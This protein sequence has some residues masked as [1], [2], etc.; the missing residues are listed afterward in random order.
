M[1]RSLLAGPGS[2]ALEEADIPRPRRGE[3]LVKVRVALTCGTDLKA[4]LRGH[5]AIPMPGPFGH[6]FSGTV[7]ARGAGVRRFKEGDGIMAVHSAPCLKCEFCRKG[8]HNLCE[9][10]MATKVLGAFSQYIVLPPH[11]VK[12]NAYPKPKSLGFEEAA[13]LEPLSCVVHGIRPLDIKRGS[14]ALVMGSG[15]IGLM[16]AMLLKSKG[17]AVAVSDPHPGR[18]RIARAVGADHTTRADR[19]NVAIKKLTG[20]V[21]FDYVFECTGRPEV[22]ED[23]VGYLRRGGTLALFGGCPKGTRVTYD[24]YRLHYDEITIK[25]VFH[26]TPADVK[27]AYGLLKGRKLP[28]GKLISGTYPLSKIETAF[29]R[30]E[31]GTGIKYAIIP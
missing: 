1:L 7:A 10:I 29:K 24:T 20:G 18:L 12:Q 15:P 13:L 19:I 11:V 28:T 2:I 3:L 23:G 6:E 31:K 8:L 4:Y 26:F 16:H 9:N 25:G 5:P 14:T 30:L 21:G 17:A 27:A 22:W